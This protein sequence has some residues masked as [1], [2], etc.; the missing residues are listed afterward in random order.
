MA[1]IRIYE[2]ATGT[3]T[4]P[5]F[6]LFSVIS[7]NPTLS[8]T[9]F[10]DPPSG[11]ISLKDA[12]PGSINISSVFTVPTGAGTINNIDNPSIVPVAVGGT[13]ISP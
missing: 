1:S 10:A 4:T 12:N 3:L 9:P 6:N 11:A 5:E 13:I 7:G 8:T 2:N